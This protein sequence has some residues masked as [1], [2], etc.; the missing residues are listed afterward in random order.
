MLICDLAR[1]IR[2]LLR[3]ARR[4]HDAP[5]TMPLSDVCPLSLSREEIIEYTP[6]WEGER[7]YPCMAG[8]RD[9]GF[10]GLTRP[11]GPA[12]PLLRS[13]SRPPSTFHALSGPHSVSL[14]SASPPSWT[15]MAERTTCIDPC[16]FEDGRPRVPDDVLTRMAAVSIT[17]VGR[18]LPPPS[19]IRCYRW[20]YC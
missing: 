7:S 13:R 3:Y 19:F 9:S 8:A 15:P 6:E 1:A 5:R 14:S 10:S 16:R 18:G 12:E 2:S 4:R 17:Q 20:L 11:R